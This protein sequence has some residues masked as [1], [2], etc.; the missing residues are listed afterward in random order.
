MEDAA[1]EMAGKDVAMSQNPWLIQP[2]AVI[3]IIWSGNEPTTFL[4]KA[5]T[6]PLDHW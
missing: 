4:F 6:L 5:D 2:N 3:R 1:Y